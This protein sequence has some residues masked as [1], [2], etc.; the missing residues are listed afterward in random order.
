MGIVAWFSAR[1]GG[2]VMANDL[3]VK[4][5]AELY[6]RKKELESE[7]ENVNK[8]MSEMEP[9][10]IEYFN[11]MGQDKV[12]FKDLG[13][14]VYIRQSIRASID[15][16]RREELAAILKD[17]DYTYLVKEDFNLNSLYALVR[18]FENNGE[19]MPTFLKEYVTPVRIFTAQVRKS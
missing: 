19:E 3:A 18:E 7:L 13:L 1:I 16:E 14:T 4:K 11:D 5:Y 9:G 6:A 8:E 2:S 17:S 12:S 15:P 10:I